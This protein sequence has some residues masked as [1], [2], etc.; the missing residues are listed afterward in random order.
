M[1][2]TFVLWLVYSISLILYYYEFYAFFHNYAELQLEYEMS[3]LI[4]GSD[5][6]VAWFPDWGIF[7][8]VI[9]WFY[10]LRLMYTTFKG[11]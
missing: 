3:E 8:A 2:S 6:S 1:L 7:V 5:F 4:G 10:L 9:L 11:M